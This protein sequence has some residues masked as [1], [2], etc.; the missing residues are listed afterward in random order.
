V[1]RSGSG[2]RCQRPRAELNR[3]DGGPRSSTH[4]ATSGGGG[5]R[6][7]VRSRSGSRQAR[8]LVPPSACL[9]TCWEPRAKRR[10]SPAHDPN[11]AGAGPLNGISAFV[12]R[13]TSFAALAAAPS[14]PPSL[15]VAPIGT[16]RTLWLHNQTRRRAPQIRR[17][18]CRLELQPVGPRPQRL[19]TA[20]PAPTTRDR[21][22]RASR[23]VGDSPYQPI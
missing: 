10:T 2:L 12:C 15:R 20:D 4:A 11:S 18:R 14:V 22:R 8:T 19:R 5:P 21:G 7:A 13:G 16:P 23:A 6:P 3:R 9:N 1:C 17:V